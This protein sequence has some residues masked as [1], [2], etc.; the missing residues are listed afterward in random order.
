[1]DSTTNAFLAWLIFDWNVRGL[2]DK[3]KRTHVYAK[4]DESNAAIVCLQETKCEKFDHSFIRSFCPKRFDQFVFS[5]SVGASGGLIILWN[6]A[7]FKGELLEIH[8]SA[9]RMK[10]TSTHNSESWNLVNVYGPCA[11]VE[12]DNFVTWLYNLSIPSNDNW[13]ILGD[14]NF[15][16]SVENRNKPGANMNDIFPAH[17]TPVENLEVEAGDEVNQRATSS[18]C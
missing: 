16:R 17:T 5:P 7:I 9:I 13:M 14:F 11:G 12:R 4:I 6:S 2:N 1:M 8:R 18:L 3:E 10:F 15:I